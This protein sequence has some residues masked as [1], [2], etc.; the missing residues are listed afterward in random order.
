MRKSRVKKSGVIVDIPNGRLRLWSFNIGSYYYGNRRLR[1]N[2]LHSMIL[3]LP[4]EWERPIS[5]NL[6]LWVDQFFPL[7]ELLWDLSVVI[8]HCFIPSEIWVSRTPIGI[9]YNLWAYFEIYFL[10][11]SFFRLPAISSPH[12]VFAKLDVGVELTFQLRLPERVRVSLS[13]WL[14][15]WGVKLRCETW[16]QSFALVEHVAGFVNLNWVALF[17][18]HSWSFLI[19]VGSIWKNLKQ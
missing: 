12:E 10:V 3:P 5:L 18:P 17:L 8:Q 14:L 16:S 11:R 9:F 4:I 1:L 6:R 15:C 19:C 2:C 13:T 7:L